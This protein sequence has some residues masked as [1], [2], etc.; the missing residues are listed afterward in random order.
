MAKTT[1]TPSSAPPGPDPVDATLMAQCRE[2]LEPLAAMK[3]PNPAADEVT[4]SIPDRWRFHRCGQQHTITAGDIDR[5]RAV[6]ADPAASLSACQ[7][8]LRPLA[9]IPT[10]FR[11]RDLE[12]PLYSVL[13]ETGGYRAVTTADIV[14]AR[15]LAAGAPPFGDR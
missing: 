8:A 15:Q 5:A 6:R 14:R 12:A 9:G 13:L 7:A 3:R 1:K 2:A 10:D 11:V 4:H